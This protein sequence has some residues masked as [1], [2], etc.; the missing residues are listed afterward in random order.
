NKA[1]L[2]VANKNLEANKVRNKHG[3]TIRHR[4]KRRE[5]KRFAALGQGRINKKSRLTKHEREFAGIKNWPGKAYLS[6][7]FPSSRL[8]RSQIA[9]ASTAKSR[10]G[11]ANDHQ[12]PTSKST[13]CAVNERLDQ[14]MDAFLGMHSSDEKDDFVPIADNCSR[15]RIRP[16]ADRSC[17]RIWNGCDLLSKPWSFRGDRTRDRMRWRL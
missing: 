10:S 6:F 8:K 1:R 15:L 2:A 5:P 7:P 12:F 11:W 17:H 4:F 14:K 3:A 13:P 16:L 9:F